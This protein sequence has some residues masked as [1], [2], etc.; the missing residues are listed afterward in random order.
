MKGICNGEPIH[1]NEKS[2]SGLKGKLSLYT[3]CPHLLGLSPSLA[4]L[5]PLVSLF[6]EHTRQFSAPVPLHWLFPLPANILLQI[7]VGLIFLPSN[8]CS[9][10]TF[11]VR[12]TLPLCSIPNS[13]LPDLFL[14][15]S[16]F[17]LTYYR[18]YLF[19]NVCLSPC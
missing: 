19:E 13:P 8:L 5:Q 18:I 9:N 10:C 4:H 1:L 7:S 15:H 11:L 6:L 16:A 3:S 2:N 14:L 12:P 17:D